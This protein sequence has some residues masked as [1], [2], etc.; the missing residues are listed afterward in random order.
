MSLIVRLKKILLSTRLFSALVIQ[1]P[2]YGYQV[3]PANA[4]VESCLRQQGREFLW[5][6]PRQSGK[7]EAVAQLCVFLLTLFHRTE[8]GIVHTYPTQNQLATGINRLER[9]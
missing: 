7:D 6:F 3:E 8:A 1:L 4:V 9:R 5:I 2:L